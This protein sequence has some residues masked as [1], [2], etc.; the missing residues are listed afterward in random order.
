M[1]YAWKSQGPLVH[2]L[3]R[4]PFLVLFPVNP[5]T[6]AKYRETFCVSRAKDDPSDAQF[7]LELLIAHRDKLHALYPQSAA[8][9]TLQQ[10]VEQRRTWSMT[11]LAS[12]TGWA[13][14]SSSTFPGPRVVQG[15]G[16]TGVLRLR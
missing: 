3:Q 11:R 12:P 7:A 9:R 8:M 14:R 1:R 2:A 6:L 15:Q 13:K 10:L 5:T 4:Y 16:H